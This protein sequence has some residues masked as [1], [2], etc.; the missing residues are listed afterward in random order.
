MR[1][2]PAAASILRDR[3]AGDPGALRFAEAV[4][5]QLVGPAGAL[6]GAHAAARDDLAAELADVLLASGEGA[7]DDALALRLLA[8][9]ALASAFFQNLDLLYEHSSAYADAAS[10]LL[11]RALELASREESGWPT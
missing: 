1:R 9:P 4:F 5:A 7:R 6:G 11:M 3:L 2:A 8:Q 10:A